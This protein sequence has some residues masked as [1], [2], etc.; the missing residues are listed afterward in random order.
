MIF[1]ALIKKILKGFYGKPQKKKQA[2]T[3]RDPK[4]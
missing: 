1:Y 3:R 4:V 2:N